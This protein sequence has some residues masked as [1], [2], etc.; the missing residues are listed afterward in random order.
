M[1]GIA[2]A[3]VQRLHVTAERCRKSTAVKADSSVIR[4]VFKCHRRIREER[5]RTKREYFGACSNLLV[6][7]YFISLYYELFSTDVLFGRRR[8]PLMQINAT[9]FELV[10]PVINTEAVRSIRVSMDTQERIVAEGRD[11]TLVCRFDVPEQQLYSVRW[12]KGDDQ[13]YSYMPSGEPPDRIFH[14][15]GVNVSRVSPQEVTLTGITRETA[16]L[17]RCEVIGEAPRFPISSAEKYVE[18]HCKWKLRAP[19]LAVFGPDDAAVPRVPMRRRALL[20]IRS[21][22]HVVAHPIYRAALRLTCLELNSPS[23]T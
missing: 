10:K 14:V 7:H 1:T 22:S 6:G 3:K 17:Y 21:H 8:T 13:F 20:S 11:A 16:G 15:E 4:H 2:F 18:V 23:R 5:Y 19:S 12:Y 9:T